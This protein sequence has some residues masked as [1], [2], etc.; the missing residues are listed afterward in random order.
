VSAFSVASDITA[1]GFTVLSFLDEVSM[2]YKVIIFS[3]H[4]SQMMLIVLLCSIVGQEH[5]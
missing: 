3:T 4:L 2:I 5:E 1:E